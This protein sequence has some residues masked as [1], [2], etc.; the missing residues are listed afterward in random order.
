[1]DVTFA[2]MIFVAGIVV[3]YLYTINYKSN[4]RNEVGE[5]RFEAGIVASAML[6]EGEPLDWN[7]TS[8][9][10]IGLMSNG[11][12]NETKI[13]RLYNLTQTNYNQTKHLLGVRYDY[14][15][16]FSETLFIE[17]EPIPGIG[18]IPDES[19]RNTIKVTRFTNY[20]DKPL[21]VEVSAWKS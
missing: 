4:E 14:F 2:A 13:A 19:A 12:L 18:R 1:M 20:Q 17:G 7:E 16:N 9:A 6:S 10:K 21:T 15:V 5:A 8:V 11:Q 3:F